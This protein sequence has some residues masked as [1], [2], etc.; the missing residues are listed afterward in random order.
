MEWLICAVI[1]AA[2]AATGLATYK[3]IFV[4]TVDDLHEEVETYW[5]LVQRAEAIVTGPP[6]NRPENFRPVLVIENDT[7]VIAWNDG[8]Q[9]WFP[10]HLLLMTPAEFDAWKAAA[11]LEALRPEAEPGVYHPGHIQ[12]AGRVQDFFGAEPPPEA[13]GKPWSPQHR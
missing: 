3:A 9:C 1:L 4:V 11:R 5:S 6:H 13:H 8:A 2:L 12:Y 7:A 10:A